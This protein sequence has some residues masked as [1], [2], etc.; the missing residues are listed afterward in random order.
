MQDR[1]VLRLEE[2][3]IATAQ[4]ILQNCMDAARINKAALAERMG[5]TRAFV[6]QMMKG[7]HNLTVRTLARAMA[8][9]GYE[10][11]FQKVPFI[12]A[13]DL[14]GPPLTER[15]VKAISDFYAN[16]CGGEE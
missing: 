2:T 12:V 5:C 15:E 3:A 1:I 4:A 7:D 10:V 9:C 16:Y 14:D 6:T 13:D 11:V 8:A